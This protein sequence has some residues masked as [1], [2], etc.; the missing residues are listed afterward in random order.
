[1]G[2][3]SAVLMGA[4]TVGS[5]ASA[6]AQAQPNQPP[7]VVQ[8]A[9]NGPWVENFNPFEPTNVADY[10]TQGA[11]YVPLFYFD[12]ENG[13]VYPWLGQSYH[14]A[15]HGLE[16]V[17][18]LKPGLKWSNG[19][20]LTAQ[21]VA[22]TYNLEH[23]QPALDIY[24]NWQ[25]LSS[26]EAQGKTT[27]VFHFKRVYTPAIWNLLGNTYPVPESVFSKVANVAKFTNPNP[28]TDGPYELLSFSP[29]VYT[30]VKNPYYV[31]APE[32]YIQKVEFP[33]YTSNTTSNLA[34]SLGKLDW[35]GTF[36]PGVQQTFVAKDP[37]HF[38]Y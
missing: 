23:S 7:L 25:Y 27:V 37:Q 5:F 38:H 20:P 19:T 21:D 24:G 3:L 10:G 31:F 35:T 2:A 26:V 12:M 34:L 33:A 36:I 13:H 9:P 32:P 8:P 1:V 22:F 14:W 16:L 15:N 4:A 30:F 29:E 28:V 6:G 11:L 18:Q 17:V